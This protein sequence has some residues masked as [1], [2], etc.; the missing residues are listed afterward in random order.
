MARL[1][2]F[3]SRHRMALCWAVLVLVII[4]A[5]SL[6]YYLRA[7]Q[8]NAK[9]SASSTTVLTA[10]ARVADVPVYIPALGS[11]T[12]TYHVTVR[13]QVNGILLRVNFKEGQMVAAGQLLAE[14]DPAPFQAQLTQ[15]EGQLLQAQAELTNAE[16]NLTRY[17]KLYPSGAVS[18]Q[19]YETQKW[20]VAQLKG[21]VQ[22]NQGQIQQVQ[23]NLEHAQITSPVEGRVGLRLVDPGN[24]VQTTDVNGL[25]VV[26]TINPITIVFSIP[27]DAIEQVQQPLSA[28]KT[29]LVEAYDRAQDQLLATGHLL[30]IDNQIDPSTGTVKLKAEFANQNGR[31]FPN[32]FVNIRLL[33]NILHN[34]VIVPTVA[35]QNGPNGAFVFVMNKANNTV[36]VRPVIIGIAAGDDTVITRGLQSGEAVIISGTDKLTNGAKVTV[37][38]KAQLILPVPEYIPRVKLQ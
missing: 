2:I 3:N 30:T 32:Q 14:I 18:Q 36:A 35:I 29:L 5:I 1:F 19:T 28:G 37:V 17:K 4:I 34:V 25:V 21:T 24:Y 23:V 33:T 16:I 6:L 12:A 20:L 11:V 26:D 22:A 10:T 9:I 8:A 31:L 38:T 15:F 7:V 27:Q 13:T